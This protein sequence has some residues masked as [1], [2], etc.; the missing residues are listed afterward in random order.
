MVETK[1]SISAGLNF[2]LGAGA[3]YADLDGFFDLKYQPVEGIAF[4]EGVETIEGKNGLGIRCG[5]E[6]KGFCGSDRHAHGV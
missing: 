5:R 4:K 3:D 2:A 1:L 6:L